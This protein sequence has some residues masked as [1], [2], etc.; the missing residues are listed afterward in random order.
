M[1]LKGLGENGIGF[2]FHQLRML[3][4]A[5][6]LP[7]SSR[8]THGGR[9]RDNLVLRRTAPRTGGSGTFFCQLDSL[10]RA[11]A[12][13][14]VKGGGDALQVGCEGQ[15]RDGF[16]LEPRRPRQCRERC[17]GSPA[18]YRPRHDRLGPDSNSRYSVSMTGALLRS[19]VGLDYSQLRAPTIAI[20]RTSQSVAFFGLMLAVGLQVRE[21]YGVPSVL[22]NQL[23]SKRSMGGL[24]KSRS[25]GGDA[26]L[27]AHSASLWAEGAKIKCQMVDSP[28]K[29]EVIWFLMHTGDSN[30]TP[31]DEHHGK[32]K[33]QT[34]GCAIIIWDEI[35]VRIEKNN[36]S[37]V[38]FNFVAVT[39]GFQPSARIPK[40]E[41]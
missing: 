37:D 22:S 40:I 7:S 36:F 24:G 20:E 15:C 32:L 8:L 23:A 38:A 26:L 39:D 31:F 30:V 10:I 28:L 14:T 13:S 17:S 1:D 2:M 5:S 9:I 3:D 12:R 41:V 21:V 33:N 4:V 16:H 11:G 6:F 29:L 25:I 35:G 27:C 19:E 34:K 18:L